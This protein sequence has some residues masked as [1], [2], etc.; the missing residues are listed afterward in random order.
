MALRLRA[1][2]DTVMAAMAVAGIVL[3]LA[4]LE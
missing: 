3:K 4:I 1:A 2:Y